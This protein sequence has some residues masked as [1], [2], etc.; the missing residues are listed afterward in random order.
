MPFVNYKKCFNRKYSLRGPLLKWL[1]RVNELH[2]TAEFYL[3]LVGVNVKP[4]FWVLF[5]LSLS[6]ALDINNLFVFMQVQLTLI[7][8]FLFLSY[9]ICCT[10]LISGLWKPSTW[11]GFRYTNYCGISLNFTLFWKL[12]QCLFGW[13][14]DEASS[15]F[16]CLVQSLAER[17]PV[18]PLSCWRTCKKCFFQSATSTVIAFLFQFCL[19]E[20]LFSSWL[21]NT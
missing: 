13:K 1:V 18:V 15:F 14:A 19:L 12:S 3:H 9:L 6:I 7:F 16:N 2:V 21:E 10:E 20:L 11:L 5:S 8:I 4:W 17:I